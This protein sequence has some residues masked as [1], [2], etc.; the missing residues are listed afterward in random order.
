MKLIYK[1]K[2]MYIDHK[3]MEILRRN[4]CIKSITKHPDLLWAGHHYWVL[5]DIDGSETRDM[6][7]AIAIIQA[8]ENRLHQFD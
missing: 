4:L 2:Q 3:A 7:P 6:D 8:S 5:K 1:I